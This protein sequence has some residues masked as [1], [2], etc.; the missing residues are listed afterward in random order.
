MVLIPAVQVGK[1]AAVKAIGSK[2]GT[3]GAMPLQSVWL[4]S[5]LSDHAFALLKGQAKCKIDV[6]G[7]KVPRL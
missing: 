4:M 6:P 3:A 7:C 2:R 5:M 1:L